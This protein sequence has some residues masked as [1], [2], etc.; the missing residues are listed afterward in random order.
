MVHQVTRT[1]YPEGPDA[2]RLHQPDLYAD[3]SEGRLVH[4]HD[5][6]AGPYADATPDALSHQQIGQQIQGHLAARD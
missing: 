5:Q 4:L 6:Y 3:V 2:L 1:T